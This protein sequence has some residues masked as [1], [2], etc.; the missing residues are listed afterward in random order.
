VA[1]EGDDFSEAVF[2]LLADVEGLL[3]IKEIKWGRP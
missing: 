1:I 2:V 3:M